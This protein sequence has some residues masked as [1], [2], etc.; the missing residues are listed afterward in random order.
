L[1]HLKTGIS[2]KYFK[3]INPSYFTEEGGGY[4][5][6]CEFEDF[7]RAIDRPIQEQA[8]EAD[9][10]FVHRARNWTLD[11]KEMMALISEGNKKPAM[12]YFSIWDTPTLGCVAYLALHGSNSEIREYHQNLLARAR[13]WWHAVGKLNREQVLAIKVKHYFNDP[14]SACYPVDDMPS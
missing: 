9:E 12:E 10:D 14:M 7:G 8:R 11:T 2:S 3:M 4:H 13:N 1:I 5:F 6:S